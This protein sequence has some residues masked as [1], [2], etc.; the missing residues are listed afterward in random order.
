M[1]AGEKKVVYIYGD[2]KAEDLIVTDFAK[3]VKHA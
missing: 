3:E 1:E 2:A